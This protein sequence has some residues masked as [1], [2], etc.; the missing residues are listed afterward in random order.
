MIIRIIL[1]VLM[2]VVAVPSVS[3]ASSGEATEQG[4]SKSRKAPR[5][6][7]AGKV[8]KRTP[9]ARNAK[10]TLSQD[11]MRRLQSAAQHEI[12]Q[13]RQQIAENDRSIKKG[14]ADLNRLGSEIDHNKKQV[15]DI[16]VQVGNLDRR[17]GGLQKD[18]SVHRQEL[19]RIRENYF[20]ALKKMRLSKGKTSALAFIF[21]SKDFNQALRRMRYLRQF[22]K[23]RD[24][25]TALLNKKVDRLEYETSLL[26]RSK[27]E[28]DRMLNKR[29]L[30]Q[31][32][33]VNQHARQDMLVVELR[34]NGSALR[35]HLQKKQ[36]EANDLRNRIAALIAEEQRKAEMQRRAAEDRRRMEAQAAERKKKEEEDRRQQLAMSQSSDN[37]Y[38]ADKKAAETDYAKARKRRPRSQN[39]EKNQTVASRNTEKVQKSDNYSSFEAA[40][41]SLPRPVAG[42]FRVTSPF[43]RHA[44]PDL[45]DVMYDNPGIDAEVSRGASVSAVF[46]GKVSGVY[47]LPGYNNVII[48]NHGAYYTIYGNISSAHVKVGDRVRQG[49]WLGNLA[50]D[51]DNDSHS[52]LHFEVWR[53]REKLNPMS[54]IR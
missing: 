36:A 34:K 54:W 10:E 45:P 19:S 38:K 3:Y 23:W 6:S 50:V 40:R 13:T 39:V 17:I 25:Q 49:Q 29:L 41:G 31:K 32:D 20:K 22:S 33:L 21:A 37:K 2:L 46:D 28:K 42:S 52:T 7:T 51:P 9:A 18:I 16:T 5:R 43:G 11:E 24:R 35:S 26:S 53:N 1:S 4:K 15:A 27:D 14:L 44:L 12:R 8:K 47:V 48:V 30:V